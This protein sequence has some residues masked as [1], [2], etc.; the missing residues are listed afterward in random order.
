MKCK[1]CASEYTTSAIEQCTMHNVH[2]TIYIIFQYK[3]IGG[4]RM[5][6]KDKMNVYKISDTIKLSRSIS[7]NRSSASGIVFSK[8]QTSE[9]RIK[10]NRS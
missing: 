10:K 1:S 9:T 3:D 4:R 8:F 6:K 2:C 7:L 5:K